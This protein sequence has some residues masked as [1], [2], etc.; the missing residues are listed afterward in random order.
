MALRPYNNYIP[1]TGAL[2]PRSIITEN[3]GDN[4]EIRYNTVA[5]M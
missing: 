2:I 1:C 4:V 5:H 3:A